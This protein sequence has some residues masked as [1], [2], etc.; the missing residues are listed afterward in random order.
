MFG[1]Y[2][3]MVYTYIMKFVHVNQSPICTRESINEKDNF[4]LSR[5]TSHCHGFDRWLFEKE[6]RRKD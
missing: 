5:N 2:M 3:F 4:I 1:I 6:T